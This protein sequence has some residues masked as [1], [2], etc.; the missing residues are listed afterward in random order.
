MHRLTPFCVALLCTLLA[1][2]SLFARDDT[3]FAYRY[4]FGVGLFAAGKASI[5]AVEVPSTRKTGVNI[6]AMPDFGISTYIPLNQDVNTGLRVEAGIYNWSWVDRPESSELDNDNTRYIEEFQ[7]IC[8]SPM[9]QLGSFVIGLNA[10]IPLS[11]GSR[12]TKSGVVSVDIP[13]EQL[14]TMLEVRLGICAPLVNSET[15]RLNL[16]LIGS[17]ALTQM[18]ESGY[19]EL[20]RA[21]LWERKPASL[22]IGLDYIF[23]INLDS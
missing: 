1:A 12:E 15:G 8:V 3:K 10:G 23:N 2:P 13:K 7:Y 4:P 5:N 16:L 19:V 18:G 9:L 17:Y 11:D 21:Y 22:S 6:A 20:G 14:S